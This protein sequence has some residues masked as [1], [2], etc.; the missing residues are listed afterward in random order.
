MHLSALDHQQ[1]L[2]FLAVV[3]TGSFSA[4]ASKLH[5]TQPAISKRILALESALGIELFERL[6]RR[7]VPT[8]AALNLLPAARRLREAMAD[9][10]DTPR[11]DGH[12]LQ[13]RLSIALSHYVG[14][15]WLP[16]VLEEF[17]QQHPAVLLDLR[18]VDSEQ[19]IELVAQGDV[20]LA[21]GTIGRTIG[22]E[23]DCQTLWQERLCPMGAA[24]LA[25]QENLPE[26][27][28]QLPMI[29]PAPHTSTRQIIDAWLRTAGITPAAVIE[30]NQLDSIAVLVGTGIG[31]SL[32]P[33]TLASSRVRPLPIETPTAPARQL[34]RI[35]LHSR[36]LNRLAT[37]FCETVA[38][39]FGDQSAS[40]G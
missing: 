6:S 21:Y 25:S 23:F 7:I 12:E 15:H 32:L 22:E 40:V 34:G 17:S 11:Q 36:S 37:A 19:A 29:L 31:W 14:L 3:E 16:E 18:F 33:E 28:R 9:L 35:R 4:A 10:L 8:D 27:L 24:R 39:R 38:R 5:L 13:G 20:R 2:A 30:V 1:V 26:R